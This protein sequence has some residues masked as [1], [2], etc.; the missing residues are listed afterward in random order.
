MKTIYSVGTVARNKVSG[1]NL[2]SQVTLNDVAG[3]ICPTGLEYDTYD[4]FPLSS[5]L[6]LIVSNPRYISVPS[7]VSIPFISIVKRNKNCVS[8]CN[9]EAD[10]L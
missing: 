6:S 1:H 9:I 7:E 3:Q 10:I 2:L 4:L 8:Y 5:A